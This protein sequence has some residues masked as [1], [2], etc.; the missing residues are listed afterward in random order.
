[1]DALTT[2]PLPRPLAAL[3]AATAVLLAGCAAAPHRHAAP[4]PPAVVAPPPTMYFYPEL[5]QDDGRQDRDRYEC[6][7]WAVRESGVDPG[8]T[9]VRHVPPP[10]AAVRD[11]GEVVAGAATGA[12]VG[13]AVSSPYRTGEGLVLGAIF[14]SLIGAAAQ[15]SRVQAAEARHARRLE[16]QQVPM[17]NFRRAMGACMSGRGYRVG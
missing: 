16:Y 1:M 11:G 15:E 6:Y 2:S 9:P 13:A 8:M 7:R 5:S 3:A 4:P 12:I 17:N 14:G 10:R